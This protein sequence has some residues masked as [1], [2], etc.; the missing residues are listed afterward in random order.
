M[1]RLLLSAITL[2]LSALSS[3]AQP[4]VPELLTDLPE[5]LNEISGTI[6]IGDALWGVADSGNPNAIY[7]FD[8]TT[9]N[10]LQT[11]V[12]TN[13]TNI[14]WEE[15]TTDGEWVFVGDFGNNLGSRTDLRVFRIPVTSLENSSTT[16]ILAEVIEFNFADQTDFTPIFDGTNWDCEAFI[17]LDDSLFIFTKNWVDQRTHLYALSADPGVHSAIRR[18]TLITQGL[19]TG[20]SLD[21]TSNTIALIGYTTTGQP[22]VWQLGNYEE[23]DFFGGTVL[24]SDIGLSLVQTESIVWMAP[25]TVYFTHEN[26][27]S[28]PARL[29]SLFL[30]LDQSINDAQDLVDQL[31][32]ISGNDVLLNTSEANVLVQVFTEDGKRVKNEVAKYGRISVIGLAPGLYVFKATIG[33]RYF[34]EVLSIAR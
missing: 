13:A 24:R 30:D 15:L 16:E 1:S 7:R 33:P 25:D 29:W 17:A 21:A 4:L 19:I 28:G 5:T 32:R 22:F 10:V 9:G 23:H 8:P 26:L 3:T 20:A 2:S 14:D 18:D 12:V 34:S 27:L 11:V 31:F 6:L